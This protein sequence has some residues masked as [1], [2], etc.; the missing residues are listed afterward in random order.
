MNS[1]YFLSKNSSD[2]EM[3]PDKVFQEN[4]LSVFH[5]LYWILC[6]IGVAGNIIISFVILKNEKMRTITNFHILNIA[7][8]DAIILVGIVFRTK[9]EW[10]LGLAAC[11]VYTVF[12][13]ITDFAGSLAIA[14]LS[15]DRYYAI[16]FSMSAVRH[17]TL[18]ITKAFCALVWF[19][20]LLFATPVIITVHVDDS[21]DSMICTIDEEDWK[22][23]MLNGREA[24]TLYSI[25]LGFCLP[26]AITVTSYV[27]IIIK[28][29]RL[30]F[31][32]KSKKVRKV[33]KFVVIIIGAYLACW[34]PY[35]IVMITYSITGVEEKGFLMML[36]LSV[37]YLSYIHSALNP[38]LYPLINSSFKTNILK[39][40][41]CVLPSKMIT[42]ED[43]DY[44]TDTPGQ[45]IRVATT[46]KVNKNVNTTNTTIIA[47]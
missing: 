45:S 16:C 15:L 18:N 3:D 21:N 25:I 13:S 23:G 14:A 10:D 30:V 1:S 8:I 24:H 29:R 44:G 2:S 31:D 7:V 46:R 6:I 40:F 37:E 34:L 9:Q 19:I 20:S 5:V 38:I 47:Q 33:T 32:N 27:F 39:L 35:W 17:R 42:S 26:F 11:K 36:Y 28:L 43:S 22:R 12:T 4:M 41:A